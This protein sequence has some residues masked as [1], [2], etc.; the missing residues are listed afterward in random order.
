MATNEATIK[1]QGA[2]SAGQCIDWTSQPIKLQ[3][4]MDYAIYRKKVR[5]FEAFEF[6]SSRLSTLPDP[7]T[8]DQFKLSSLDRRG[9]RI[10]KDAGAFILDIYRELEA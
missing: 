6:I 1:D 5:D 9:R 2:G 10:L 4:L 7:V 8:F 3:H